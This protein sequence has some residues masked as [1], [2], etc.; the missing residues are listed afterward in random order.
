LAETNTLSS[1]D[2]TV[3]ESG[4]RERIRRPVALVL[5]AGCLAAGVFYNTHPRRAVTLSCD[6]EGDGRVERVVLQAGRDPALSVWRGEGRLWQ[7][8][9][10]HWKP[11]KVSTADVDGDGKREIIVGVHKA[12][13]FFPKPHNCLFVYGWDGERAFPK[14]LGSSLSRPFT[15]FAF[16]DVDGDRADELIALETTRDDA[17]CVSVY[18]WS[19]FGFAFDYQ[20]GPWKTA[21][22]IEQTQDAPVVLADGKQVVVR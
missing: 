19:G 13:R 14:W 10:K 21:R 15:D 18:S 22:F 9:P 2:G 3:T 6:L 7:G 20:R 11:W 5:L 17:R 16:A 8:V 1:Q 4:A 12:T